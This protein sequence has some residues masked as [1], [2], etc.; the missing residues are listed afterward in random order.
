MSDNTQNTPQ[1]T[2]A[3]QTTGHAWDGDLQEYNNPL[4]RWWLWCFYG[5]AVFSVLYWLFYPSWPVGNTW[6]KGFGTVS[7]TITD[8]A[9]GKA[10]EREH[11]WNTRAVLLEDLGAADR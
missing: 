7:Y 9:T 11:R 1:T 5:T 3:V 8:K 10:Q 6:I 2:G 4:P